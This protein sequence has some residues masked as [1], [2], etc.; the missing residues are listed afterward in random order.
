MLTYY[1]PVLIAVLASQHALTPQEVAVNKIVAY[2]QSSSNSIPTLQDYQTAGINDATEDNLDELN[3]LVDSLEPEDVDSVSERANLVSLLSINITPIA[4]IEKMEYF[5]PFSIQSDVIYKGSKTLHYYVE[6][7]TTD[8]IELNVTTSG[9]INIAAKDTANSM[10]QSEI[11]LIAFTDSQA[12]SESFKLDVKAATFTEFSSL[13]FTTV[14]DD[15][16]NETAVR[17]VLQTFA[18]GGHATDVQI[19]TW[20]D[21]PPRYAIVQMLNFDAYNPLLSPAQNP[22]P[23]ST[24]LEDLASFWSSSDSNNTIYT[25]YHSY[26]DTSSWASPS[27]TWMMAVMMRGFNPFLHRVGLWET[28]YHMS[29]NQKAGIYPEPLFHHYDNIINTV[30]QNTSYERVMAKGAK[31]AAVAYQY[32]HNYNTFEG[33]VFRGNE[34]FAREYHQLFFGILGDYDHDYHETTAIAN[35]ARALT[36]MQAYWHPDDEG[37]PDAEVTFGTDKHYAAD[38]DILKTTIGGEDASQKIDA[39]AVVAIEHN[40]SLANLPIMIAKHFADDNLTDT[41]TAT[42]QESWK[43]MHPKALL[44]FLWAYATS[45]DFHS[46]TRFKYVS[47]IQRVMHVKNLLGVNNEEQRY[48]INYPGWELEDENI[49]VF[50][51]LHDVFGHQSGLEASDNANIFRINYNRSTRWNWAYTKSYDCDENES[52]ECPKDDDGNDILLWEKDWAAIIPT[53]ADGEYVAEDVAL[54][55][56]K[57]F[58]ADGGKHYGALERAHIISLLNGKDLSLLLDENDPLAIYDETQIQSDSAIVQRLDDAAIARL[59]LNSSD[60]DKRRYANKN[61]GLAI[62]FI[63]ATPYIFVEEGL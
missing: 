7:N 33:G 2:A 34:D 54:W 11:T 36:D 40:E 14:S 63:A 15:A 4:N 9:E 27:N 30:A 58:I 26:F 24:S 21:M 44:P 45:T 53:N 51:P 56:W 62:A 47:S 1:V 22:L 61:V 10:G 8:H 59:E 42:I 19:K 57:R 41:K 17:K 43:Q 16:W 3:Y 12:N 25:K 48:M 31:N 5:A 49:R 13:A 28:N 39:I 29:V 20:A 46:S 60:K 35:T 32:G 52:Y 50:V 23:Q 55:L 38:L 18:Y 37:G 6:S